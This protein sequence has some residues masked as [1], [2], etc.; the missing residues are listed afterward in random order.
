MAEALDAALELELGW[1]GASKSK[2]AEPAA[3]LLSM[4]PEV[5]F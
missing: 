1:M 3:Y 4:A 2:S 5:I